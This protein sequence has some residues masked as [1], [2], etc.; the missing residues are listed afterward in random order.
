MGLGDNLLA[1]GMARGAK[2]RGKRIAFGDGKKI[3]WDK[4]SSEVFRGNPNVAPPGAERDQDVQWVGFYKGS[5]IYNSQDSA[6]KRWIWNYDFKPTPGE[7]FFN[8]AEVR[9]GKRYGA[10]FVILEP[11]VPS[12]KSVAP[13]KDWGRKNWQALADK[14]RKDGH[15]LAAFRHPR[16]GPPLAGVEHFATINFRDA[17]AILSRASLYIGPEG[18]LHHAAAA[19]NRKA[20]VLFGGFIPPS[21]T[22]YATHTNLTGGAEACG[23][24]TPCQHCKDA[25]AAISVGE[26][27][28]AATRLL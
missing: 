9:N 11:D 26:V 21:V 12:W 4:H 7:L 6:N 20:V 14:L 23:N 13:N 28:D 22:G 18:G 8:S 17:A 27:H 3:L 25:L 24:Y 16:S 19:M 10:G 1:T 15:R 5:R 2:A